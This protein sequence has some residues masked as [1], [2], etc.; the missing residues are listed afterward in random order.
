MGRVYL[1]HD[2]LIWPSLREGYGLPPVE[3]MACGCAVAT[4]ANGG[5]DEFAAPGRTALV[6]A[7]GDVDALAASVVRLATDPPMR[8]RLAGEAEA[9]VRRDL[10]WDA[11]IDAWERALIDDAPWNGVAP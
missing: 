11:V 2:I 5:S 1:D 8:R 10:G 7:A 9:F 6:S 4:T 3:A